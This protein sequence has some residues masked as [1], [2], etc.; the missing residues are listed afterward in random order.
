MRRRRTAIGHV[1]YFDAR[2]H[3]EQFSTEMAQIS[4]TTRAQVYSARVG[5]SIGN[6][7]GNCF[8]RE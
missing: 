2:H 4:G 1:N 8:D 6:K 3:L 7:L 5:F